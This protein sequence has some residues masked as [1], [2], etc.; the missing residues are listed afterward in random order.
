MR[1]AATSVALLIVAG[2]AVLLSACGGGG[3]SSTTPT[4]PAEATGTPRAL[5]ASL[6]SDTREPVPEWNLQVTA[7]WKGKDHI[8]IEGSVNLPGS[9]T[10][11]Y[12]VCQDGQATASLQR[13]QN[14]EYKNGKITA[15]SKVV[16]GTGIGPPFD[17]N[18][19]FDVMISILGEPVQVPYFIVRV[20]VEGKPG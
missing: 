17:P 12:W 11:N 7:K 1:R 2:V 9:G 4:P 5:P 19:H 14:P 18:A 13:S 3:N 6:C 8:V 16:E 20:P 15:E 10:V